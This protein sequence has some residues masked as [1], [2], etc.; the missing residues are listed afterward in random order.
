MINGSGI[1]SNI[2][3]CLVAQCRFHVLAARDAPAEAG[4]AS[5]EGDDDLRRTTFCLFEFLDSLGN[6]TQAG[7]MVEAGDDGE[8][9]NRDDLVRPIKPHRFNSTAVPLFRGVASTSTP[10]VA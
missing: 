6:P 1:V 2:D 5:V 7:D 9:A 10:L 3:N 4:F 8:I